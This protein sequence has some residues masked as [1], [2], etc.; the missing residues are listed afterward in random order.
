MSIDVMP[1]LLASDGHE[2]A[3]AIC[4]LINLAAADGRH[5]D[6]ATLAGQARR[7]AETAA[8]IGCSDEIIAATQHI[9][10]MTWACWESQ[11]TPRTPTMDGAS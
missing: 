7:D 1:E 3:D 11:T 2:R 9:A 5:Q 6:A 8:Q 4:H 10:D